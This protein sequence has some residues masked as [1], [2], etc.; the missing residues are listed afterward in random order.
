MVSSL[1]V[2]AGVAPTEGANTTARHRYSSNTYVYGT[3]GRCDSG[4]TPSACQTFRGGAF[5]KSASKSLGT[6]S[7]DAYPADASP[8]NAMT[9]ITDTLQLSS[10]TSLPNF[11]LGIPINDLGTQAYYPQMTLGLASNSTLLNALKASGKI[12]SR[13]FSFFAGKMGATAATQSE[14]GM[15]FGGYDKS[16]VTGKQYT[17]PM[18]TGQ[19]CSTNLVV[20]ITDIQL[21]FPNGDNESLF[22]GSQSDSITACLSPSLPVFMNLPLQP[23][24]NKWLELSDSNLTIYQ[25]NRAVGINFWNMRY[26][27]GAKP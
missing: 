1:G 10:D 2:C 27:P 20:T 16:K 26:P 19:S 9:Y 25:M 23:Y 3:D 17:S 15:V 13:T 8:Y 7:T 6:P 14:G 24:F 22:S 11:P 12:A 21:N 4:W 5:D 18:A